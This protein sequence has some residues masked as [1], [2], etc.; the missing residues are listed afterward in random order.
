MAKSDKTFI[1]ASI[2]I[3]GEIDSDEGVV[4][5]GR[6]QGK[7]TCAQDVTVERGA[8]VEAEVR[9]DVVQVHGRVVGPVDARARVE[10]SNEAQVTGDV[11]SPRIL[12]ADG[13][14]YKGHID[15]S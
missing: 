4:L 14:Q 5:E 9:A 6:V 11:R 15:M 7:I 3:D 1:G 13:A 10:L 2:T 8:E 12:I